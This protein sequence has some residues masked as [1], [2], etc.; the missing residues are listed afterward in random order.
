MQID[1]QTFRLAVA[2]EHRERI[3]RR[4]GF[5]LSRLQPH[6]E[7]VEVR[8]SDI[9]GAR[10]GVD[11]QCRVM[12]TLTQGPAAVVEDLDA[13][14]PTLIDRAMA[15]A[16]RVA[17]KRLARGARQRAEPRSSLPRLDYVT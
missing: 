12:V 6:V 7:R 17:A 10:G 3:R 1:I 11:K 8:L 4:A 5:A 16:G 9:N 13:D 15:R 2:P 14:L